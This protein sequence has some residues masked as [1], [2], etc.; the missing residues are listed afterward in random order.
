MPLNTHYSGRLIRAVKRTV[1]KAG[2]REGKFYEIFNKYNFFDVND[3]NNGLT[4]EQRA[5]VP[6][7][8]QTRYSQLSSALA[9]MFYFVLGDGEYGVLANDTQNIL[10]KLD[11]R[12]SANNAQLNAVGAGLQSLNW[13]PVYGRQMAAIDATRRIVDAQTTAVMGTS[14]YNADLIPPIAIGFDGLPVSIA[15]VFKSGFFQPNWD[16]LYKQELVK[17]NKFYSTGSGIKLGANILLD[18]GGTKRDLF[19]KTIFAVNTTD[20]NLNPIG[21]VKGGVTAEE[22]EK[23]KRAAT[24]TI[25]EV[26]DDEELS[27]FTLT[28]AQMQSSYFRYVQLKLWG[29]IINRRNWAHGHWGALTNNACPEYVKT[30]VC[31]FL[32]TNGIALE[33]N[34]SDISAFIS[35]CVT[36]G[37]YYLIGYRY[38]VRMYGISDFDVI[39]DESGNKVPITN[40][41]NIDAEYGLPKDKNIAN[42]YFTWVADFLL[43]ITADTNGDE[44]GYE[45]RKRRVAEANLIYNGVG[46]PPIKFGAS[47]SDLP[48]EHTEAGLIE[49][50]FDKICNATIFRYANDGAPGGGNPDGTLSQP[51]GSGVVIKYAQNA[52]EDVV[53]DLSKAIIRTLCDE[54]GITSAYLTSTF[55]SEEDQARAM[56]NNLQN[57]KTWD[58]YGSK[59]AKGGG[60][61]VVERY[62]SAK[63]ER[64][65][66]RREPVTGEDNITYVKNAMIEEIKYQRNERGFTISKHLGD[67]TIVQAIDIGP[68]SVEPQS[69]KPAFEAVCSKAVKEG[70]LRSFLVPKKDPAYHLE[71][72]QEA[73]GKQTFTGGFVNNKLPEIE[74]TLRST[75]Y[76]KRS[77]WLAPLSRD[78]L[79][80]NDAGGKSIIG[81]IV[82]SLI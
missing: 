4:K 78:S 9:E 58:L 81:S 41:G 26:E 74:F 73:S 21:D 37:I 56:F 49:R 68:N 59:A 32:W 6:A 34:K 18:Q 70:W 16:F 76:S 24:L 1:G 23:I 42:R 65:F 3:E 46:I 39:L 66:A 15:N 72:W 45:I 80:T 71:I 20:K 57:N 54:A 62:A 17:S 61:A 64:G 50:K 36:M 22:F 8:N 48:F 67:G 77:T 38:K 44:I 63:A 35:Y 28:D 47:V 53:S 82:D 13:I 52:R 12:S 29:S 30:A 51:E 60:Y 7:I 27:N 55:R 33:N 19:L 40:D 75:T 5:Q 25:D 10:D 14:P 11:I 79:I 31:S 2:G 69:R 43:R